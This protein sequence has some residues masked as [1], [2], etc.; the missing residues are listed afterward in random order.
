MSKAINLTMLDSGVARI[1]IDLPGSKV[2]LLSASVMGELNEALDQIGQ[3]GAC[4]GVMLVS[5][6]EDFGAGANVEEIQALQKQP[7]IKIYEATKQG[8]ALFARLE[9]LNS[10]AV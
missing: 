10:I 4:K 7:G 5:G 8:K 1:T 6:K 9:K 2:N 3:N